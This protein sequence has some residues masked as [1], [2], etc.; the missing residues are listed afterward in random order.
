MNMQFALP[1]SVLFGT[2]YLDF[3]FAQ[4]MALVAVID[5]AATVSEVPTGA[6]A[7]RYGYLFVH[8]MGLVLFTIPIVGFVF[9][10]N[11]YVLIALQCL[12]G[13][14]AAMISGALQAFV[15]NSLPSR[16]RDLIN[17]SVASKN[18]AAR[19]L[20]RAVAVLAGSFLYSRNPVL[21]YG[22]YATALTVSLWLAFTLPATR[23]KKT[24]A[25][26]NWQQTHET[27][28]ML[29]ATKQMR[30]FLP[31]VVLFQLFSRLFGISISHTLYQFV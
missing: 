11:F 28:Q 12:G 25:V 5:L 4:T 21:P 14:G 27:F 15:Y 29:L 1:I 30:S 23:F 17:A 20:G 24:E 2:Q 8:R 22:M 6:W 7:D 19:H 3:S 16:N 10:H 26:S 9:L 18:L 13:L 31:Q